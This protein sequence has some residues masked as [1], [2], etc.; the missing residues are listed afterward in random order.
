M[1]SRVEDRPSGALCKGQCCIAHAWARKNG[2]ASGFPVQIPF[3]INDRTKCG[4]RAFFLA[5]ED[6]SMPYF[7]FES[8]INGHRN[9]H[10]T[11]AQL[12]QAA[13]HLVDLFLIHMREH[14]M[15]TD[16]F[17]TEELPASK[18]AL[19]NAFRVVIATESR[20]GVRALLVKAGMTLAQFQDN[21][22]ARMSVKPITGSFGSN[23]RSDRLRKPA[24]S[25]LR[26]FDHALMRLGEDRTRLVQVFQ[27]ATEIAEDKPR[28]H[29]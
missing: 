24:A 15:G 3:Q 17:D 8:A 9:I 22:G 14:D 28:H 25:D 18:E 27:Q 10:E 7:D 1:R 12:L 6:V 20:T 26:R 11:D 5:K 13:H 19:I 2:G 4:L 23:A 29:A 21:I 16:L